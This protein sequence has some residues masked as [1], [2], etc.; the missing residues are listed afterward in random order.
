MDLGCYRRDLNGRDFEESQEGKSPFD[1]SHG[2]IEFVKKFIS[3]E[4]SVHQYTG[5]IRQLKRLKGT[6]E[7]GGT[8]HDQ[9]LAKSIWGTKE[10]AKKM[11]SL[12]SD[13][14]S[15]PN[16]K[17]VEEDDVDVTN[18][19]WFENSFLLPLIESLGV[20]SVKHKWSVVPMEAKKK[21]EERL[22]LLE[23]D[24]G[25]CKK[26]KETL[27]IKKRECLKQ[28]TDFLNEVIDVMT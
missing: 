9:E 4:A 23:A 22:E 17:M 14:F 18:S 8:K 25:E 24:E 11:D 28:K 7:T 1:D 27:K 16:G 15:S 13:L 21:I 6:S 19:D 3:F 10:T 12:K 20:D 26:I 5:K 2:F